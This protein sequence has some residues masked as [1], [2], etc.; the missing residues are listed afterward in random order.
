MII[1]GPGFGV[2]CL[3]P[4]QI[5]IATS[6]V[7]SLHE[8]SIPYSLLYYCKTIKIA[9]FYIF[10]S[11][12]QTK[13]LRSDFSMGGPGF[14]RIGRSFRK[15]QPKIIIAYDKTSMCRFCRTTKARINFRL[16]HAE[17]I[18]YVSCGRAPRQTIK[19]TPNAT[20]ELVLYG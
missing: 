16:P 19:P 14:L 5:R 13:F 12:D 9:D 20:N 17:Y 6:Q 3:Y 7:K 11:L 2:Q 1:R 8:N 4:A 15:I 18:Y 10:L